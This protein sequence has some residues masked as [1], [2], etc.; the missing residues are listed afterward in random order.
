MVA[1]DSYYFS[2]SRW[3]TVHLVVFLLYIGMTHTISVKFNINKPSVTQVNETGF[4]WQTYLARAHKINT[5]QFKCHTSYWT[6]R[7]YLWQLLYLGSAVTAGK[8]EILQML[9]ASYTF[10]TYSMYRSTNSCNDDIIE[11]GE[12]YIV[13]FIRSY[14][15]NL[16]WCSRKVCQDVSLR[17]FLQSP[18]RSRKPFKSASRSAVPDIV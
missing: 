8:S 12:F 6:V 18:L 3:R 1:F 4:M 14:V 11:D 2:V 13:L 7:V 15:W 5:L 10:C 9:R 17:C 16:V